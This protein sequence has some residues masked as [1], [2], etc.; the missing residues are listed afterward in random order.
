MLR[1]FV[2]LSKRRG[3]SLHTSKKK[4][5]FGISYQT[6]RMSVVSLRRA[7]A[8]LRPLVHVQARKKYICGIGNCS[9]SKSIFHSFGK[10]VQEFTGLLTFSC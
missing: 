10:N 8:A 4:K 5:F 1:L 3:I 6:D 2:I 9:K 7:V